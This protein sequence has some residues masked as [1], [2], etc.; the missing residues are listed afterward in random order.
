[1]KKALFAAIFCLSTVVLAATNESLSTINES[2]KVDSN[3]IILTSD[4][5]QLAATPAKKTATVKKTKK[6]ILAAKNSKFED[7]DFKRLEQ[8]LDSLTK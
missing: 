2:S 6:Q 3:K 4:G 8:E 7:D 5:P 1:M